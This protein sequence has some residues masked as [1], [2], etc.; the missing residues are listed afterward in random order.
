MVVSGGTIHVLY[1]IME[2]G[3]DIA[4]GVEQGPVDALAFPIMILN[5]Y[6]KVS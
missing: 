1:S 4:I 6:I 3:Y 2:H 5:R